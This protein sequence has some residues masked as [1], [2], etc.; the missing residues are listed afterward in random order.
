MKTKFFAGVIVVAL[1]ALA[2]STF[3]A[4]PA[5]DNMAVDTAL[6]NLGYTSIRLRKTAMNE[7]EVDATVNG[8]KSIP[9][10]LSFQAINTIFNTQRLTELGIKYEK[11]GQEFE[12]NGDEDD[13]Y[14]VRTDSINISD[15]KIGPEEVMC[16]DFNEFSAFRDYRVS[17][18]LGRDFLIKYDA[19]I[20]FADQK[21]FLKTK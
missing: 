3:H 12:V 19:I 2:I 20:D 15:G 4:A 17:G 10:L 5:G 11:A 18:I 9:M 13:L 6:R 16:I 7:F 8:S 14:V 1:L 21:L